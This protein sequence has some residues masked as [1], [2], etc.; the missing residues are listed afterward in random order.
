MSDE[1]SE[2]LSSL[3]KS[4]EGTEV[5]AIL[6]Q[7]L[8][9]LKIKPDASEKLKEIE[10]ERAWAQRYQESEKLKEDEKRRKEEERAKKARMA[11]EKREKLKELQKRKKEIAQKQRE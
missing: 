11:E 9:E 6:T 8:N 5:H 7:R 10:A 4:F 1:N 2:S 3:L